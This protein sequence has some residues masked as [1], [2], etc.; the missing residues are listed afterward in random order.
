VGGVAMKDGAKQLAEDV[1]AF[2]ERTCAAQQIATKLSDSEALRR[3]VALLAP[4]KLA[5][6]AAGRA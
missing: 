2:V 1:R 5:S 3:V 6:Q 4:E